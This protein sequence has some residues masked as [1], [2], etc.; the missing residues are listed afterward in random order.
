MV[1][2][3]TGGCEGDESGPGASLPAAGV[4]GIRY[5]SSTDNSDDGFARTLA[6]R[7]FVFPADHASHPEFRTEWWY[8][9]G[10][11]FDARER[12]YGFELTLFRVALAPPGAARESA[13]AA[14]TVWMGHLAVTDTA[15]ERF[16]AAERLS[17]G[18]AGLAGASSGDGDAP[19]VVSVEDWSV[20]IDGDA[21]ALH[22]SD[23]GFG[24]D[25]DLTGL[26]RIVAQGDGGLDAKGPE[27]G[28]ASYY[29]SAPRLAV[30]GRLHSAGA[31]AVAVTG[32][33]WMDREWSTSALSPDLTGW[34][35]F[36]LQLDDGRDLMFYRLRR[37]D[38]ST[39]AFSGGSLTDAAGKTTRLSADDVV[40][41]ATREWTSPTTGV[42][43][44]VA[45]RFA[46]QGQGL[47]LALEPRLDAQEL[48]LSVRYWE[49]AV[50]VSGEKMG[51]RISGAGYVELA[52]Y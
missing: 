43:Y 46:L 48:D 3:A 29:F 13:L 26:R 41:T 33:A 5:L 38:G 45:W 4:S 8:F 52:G 14:S 30:T 20:T 12:H 35:W 31:D 17:R 50:A 23:G 9:T 16:Q 21:V 47:E 51:Q 7:P 24:I 37:A 11:V 28:N 25:L 32:T 22:A 15:A 39:S 10:N 49:G 40:L 42:R 2:A 27:P 19:V 6:P 44:P 1:L 34:D 36:A 18:A